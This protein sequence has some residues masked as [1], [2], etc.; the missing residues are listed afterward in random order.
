MF[1]VGSRWKG[2]GKNVP[3]LI[4][5]NKQTKL[6]RQIL[7]IVHWPELSL[8]TIFRCKGMGKRI[9]SGMICLLH[10]WNSVVKKKETA[11]WM[12]HSNSLP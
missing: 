2:N 5:R 3:R 7:L 10:D 12:T 6:S 4:L 1:Q 8:R 11:V 9:L